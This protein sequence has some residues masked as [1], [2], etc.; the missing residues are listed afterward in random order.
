MRIL[1]IDDNDMLRTS[2][3]SSLE[4]HGFE[5]V[6]R[7]NGIKGLQAALAI[8]P[9]RIL[10]D[11]D[12][13]GLNGREVYDQLPAPLQKCFFL[14]SG[15]PPPPDFP[16]PERVIDIVAESQASV[17]HGTSPAE[18]AWSVNVVISAIDAWDMPSVA[19]RLSLS[20]E[21]AADIGRRLLEFAAR[22]GA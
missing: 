11:Y 14:F 16:V 19:A 13:P 15:D 22:R 18:G 12:M 7:E 1:L 17:A 20:P 5:V 4:R 9:D 6:C 10:C 8:E 21:E 3:S 2:I